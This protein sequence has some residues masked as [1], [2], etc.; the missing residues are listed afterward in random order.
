MPKYIRESIEE[1]GLTVSSELE[2]AF[3]RTYGD[4]DYEREIEDYD[5]LLDEF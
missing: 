1:A 2:R 4:E 5:P 3:E